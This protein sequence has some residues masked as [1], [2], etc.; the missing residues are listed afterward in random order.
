[1][2]E[3]QKPCKSFLGKDC[4]WLQLGPPEN[5][6]SN[7]DCIVDLITGMHCRA[8]IEGEDC[9]YAMPIFE[10]QPAGT[11]CLVNELSAFG[12]PTS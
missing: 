3:K 2:V 6:P 4:P 10:A 11:G 12:L 1:M 5:L 9:N 7:R 8:C